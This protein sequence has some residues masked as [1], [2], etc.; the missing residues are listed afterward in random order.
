MDDIRRQIAELDPARRAL[1][2]R[3]LKGDAAAPVARPSIA[4]RHRESETAPVSFAQQRLW[5]LDQLEPGKVAFNGSHAWLLTGP[6]RVRAVEQCFAEM[7]RRHEVLRTTFKAVAGQPVQVIRPAGG[8]SLP[9]ESLEHLPAGEREEAARRLWSEEAA[10]PFDLARGPLL[11]LRLLRLGELE[12]VVLFTI[13]HIITDGWSAG[14]ITE[15]MVKLYSAFAAGRPSPLAELPVQYADYAVWQREWL[16][17]AEVSKHLA[18]WGP[19]L[20]GLPVVTLP[21]D[22]PRP[23]RRSYRG[24]RLPVGVDA[25]LTEAL[26]ALSR[27]EGATLFMTLLAAFALLLHRYTGQTDVVVGT[28]IA[29]R[30]LAETERLI[31]FFVNQLALRVDLSGEPTFRE[32]LRR[33]QR[34]TL[35]AYAHQELPFERLVQALRPERSLNLHPLFQ[36]KVVFQN[37]PIPAASVSELTMTPL[38]RDEPTAQF[39]LI[40]FF[41]E[42]P[43]GLGGK[44]EYSTDL[45]DGETVER[46]LGHLDRLLRSIAAGPDERVAALEMFTAE[47]AARRA[48][49]A[50]ARADA[51]RRKLVAARRIAVAPSAP[52]D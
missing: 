42:M 1:L 32:L 17:D 26:R 29:N 5:F 48:A 21:P 2:E 15:E 30:T 14:V 7:I 28:D 16:T 4:R 40:I 35:D 43:D 19:Q 12:H 10:R 33:V 24:A 52:A 20:A 39:D 45:F 34:M 6:L 47:D 31:G 23:A 36:V 37:V 18:Y 3:L 49:E 44:A 13:H 11:R 46:L 9:V 25:G 22:R 41:W 50:T 8:L 38:H 27:E 51:N